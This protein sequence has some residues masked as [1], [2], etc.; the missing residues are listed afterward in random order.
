MYEAMRLGE[1]APGVGREKQLFVFALPDV[2]DGSPS[3]MKMVAIDPT[4]MQSL[5]QQFWLYGPKSMQQ[6]GRARNEAIQSRKPMIPGPPQ[7]SGQRKKPK[8]EFQAF[9]ELATRLLNVPRSALPS[10][11]TTKR[12]PAKRTAK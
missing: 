11:Q 8:S 6:T 10:S 4:A 1:N 12:K 7:A 3:Y 5:R 2:G 9:D